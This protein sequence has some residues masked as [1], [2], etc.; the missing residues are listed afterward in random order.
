MLKYK[1]LLSQNVNKNFTKYKNNILSDTF[2]QV[3]VTKTPYLP[4]TEHIVWNVYVIVAYYATDQSTA[5]PILPVSFS[6]DL[7]TGHTNVSQT[8]DIN[9]QCRYIG[10]LLHTNSFHLKPW[11]LHQLP[12]LLGLPYI[13][14][15]LTTVQSTCQGAVLR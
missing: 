4:C 10:C 6:P 3:I 14:W 11:K 2:T 8:N 7:V 13:W 1:Y 5:M 9:K 12:A 15:S